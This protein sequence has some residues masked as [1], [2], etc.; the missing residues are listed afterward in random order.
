LAEKTANTSTSV[1]VIRPRDLS[2]TIA[3]TVNDHL[4]TTIAD[5]AGS[6]LRMIDYHTGMYSFPLRRDGSFPAELQQAE[7]FVLPDETIEYQD[8]KSVAPLYGVC[9]GHSPHRVDVIRFSEDID[10]KVA[11]PYSIEAKYPLG[12]TNLGREA[13][14]LEVLR[15]RFSRKFVR[16][17][18]KPDD[19]SNTRLK[20]YDAYPV[21]RSR[22]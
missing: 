5:I 19:G 18:F 16:F 7:K 8:C 2:Y 11:T 6:R 17:Y 10:G 21:E 22:Q 14:T 4:G 1:L 3:G 15:D 12:S 9:A 13:M 20:I